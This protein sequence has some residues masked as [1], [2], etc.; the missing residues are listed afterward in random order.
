LPPHPGSDLAQ[1][2]LAQGQHDDG[3]TATISAFVGAHG[4]LLATSAP[5][6][7]P[8]VQHNPKSV[9]CVVATFTI[10]AMSTRRFSLLCRKD[11]F[12]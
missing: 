12:S 2:R 9:L 5:F 6:L 1:P 4:A 11:Y 3:V 8:Y 7:F 10:R